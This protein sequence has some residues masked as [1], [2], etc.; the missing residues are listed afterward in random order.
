MSLTCIPV[1]DT[2]TYKS[3]QVSPDSLSI[4]INLN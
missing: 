4:Q 1:K 2:I 3:I